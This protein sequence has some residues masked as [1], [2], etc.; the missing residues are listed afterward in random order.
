[1]DFLLILL[2]LAR[3]W[4]LTKVQVAIV[5]FLAHNIDTVLFRKK[6]EHFVPW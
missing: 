4:Q 6:N 1:M 5:I 3:C 2:L